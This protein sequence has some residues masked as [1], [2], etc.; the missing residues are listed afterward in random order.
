MKKKRLRLDEKWEKIKKGEL[1]SRSP[2]EKRKKPI[3]EPQ[4]RY[5]CKNCQSIVTI[6]KG[7]DE[8]KIQCCKKPEMVLLSVEHDEEQ[9]KQLPE[10]FTLTQDILRKYVDL[11]EHYYPLI[12]LWIMG[13]YMHEDFNTFPLL[14]I[15]ATKGSGKS[16]LIK[17][18]I[19]LSRSGKLLNDLKESVLFRTAK[20][21]T[22]GIDEFEHIGNKEMNTLRT[23][24][25]SAYKKG[26]AVERM[27]KV[28]K[29]GKETFEVEKFDLFTPIALANI[30]G[31]EEV[32]LD[33]CL[34]ILLDKSVDEIKTRLI[35]DFDVNPDIHRVIRYYKGIWCSKCS[36]VTPGKREKDDKSWNEYLLNRHINYTNNIQHITTLTTLDIL[37]NKIFDTGLDGRSLELFYPLFI[38]AG[39]VGDDVLD[40]T[41]EI[42]KEIVE[43]KK[44]DEY[45]ENKDVSLIDFVSRKPEYQIHFVP[46]GQLA[47]E[48]KQFVLA[49][50][51]DTK[52]L[53]SKWMGRAL[54]RLKLITSKRRVSKGVE[55]TL[56]V[57]KAVDKL[58]VFK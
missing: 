13:T 38:I 44:H 10:Y 40:N 53:N 41:L 56:N 26:V 9:I 15:N 1:P 31:L 55:V 47:L 2:P 35:E 29:D 24:L 21:N 6:N 8:K 52:W 37:Y 33:R 27:R 54:K 58:K 36:V 45:A 28:S 50:E 25:N 34:T 49:D 32:L 16:R 4:E 12:T 20:G 48:F 7:D 22:I 30:W 42:A 43:E 51:E 11:D 3:P 46:I 14:F 5:E 19:S 17:L 18:I 23:M 57:P 39:M